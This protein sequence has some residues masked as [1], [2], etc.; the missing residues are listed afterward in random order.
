VENYGWSIQ[1]MIDR[2]VR[3][4]V[5]CLMLSRLFTFSAFMQ[6]RQQLKGQPNIESE[7]G[8]AMDR[9]LKV[10]FGWSSRRPGL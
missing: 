2:Y 3:L 1:L 4:G 5:I 6:T 7:T 10:A 8:G 9:F